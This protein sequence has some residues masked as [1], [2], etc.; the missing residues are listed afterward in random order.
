MNRNHSSHH[1]YSRIS[2]IEC[3]MFTKDTWLYRHSTHEKLMWTINPVGL[4]SNHIKFNKEIFLKLRFLK[5][6][7]LVMKKFGDRIRACKLRGGGGRERER[8]LLH[9]CRVLSCTQVMDL[10]DPKKY[11][12]RSIKGV[13]FANFKNIF[14]FNVYPYKYTECLV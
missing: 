10:Q 3:S 14:F 12:F 9:P 13:P 4:L 7:S 6:R 5:W 1:W 8:R 2:D 11:S